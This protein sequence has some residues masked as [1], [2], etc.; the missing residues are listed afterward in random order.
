MPSTRPRT[1]EART[2]R[3]E[4]EEATD[5]L[6]HAWGAWYRSRARAKATSPSA[7]LPTRR[8]ATAPR[9]SSS[10]ASNAEAL[11][12]LAGAAEA[13]GKGSATMSSGLND[14]YTL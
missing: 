8:R 3:A 14:K 2:A 9:T 6:F 10:N 1:P 5:V 13:A 7:A 4:L 12:T 11:H